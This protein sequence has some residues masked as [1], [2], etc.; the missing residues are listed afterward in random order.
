MRHLKVLWI[1]DMASWVRTVQTNLEI[2]SKKYD[3]TIHIISAPNGEGVVQL[4]MM[5][6]FDYVLMDYDMNPFKGDK[7]IRDIRSEEHLEFIPII[8]YSQHT[9]VSL[10]DLVDDMANIVTVFR[11]NL[12][13]KLNEL[14]FK[15]N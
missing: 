10:S 8:F 4:C 12:E 5:H 1:D 14:F 6:N 7:Y 9:S 3:V 13:D 2:V 11:P 15:K